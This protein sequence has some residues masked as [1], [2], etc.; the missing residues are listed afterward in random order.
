MQKVVQAME[1]KLSAEQKVQKDL[2]AYHI[3]VHFQ[4]IRSIYI[5]SLQSL[6]SS[7]EPPEDFLFIRSNL[8]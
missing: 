1:S 6:I 8:W 3:S 7:I 2:L 4:N 5:E